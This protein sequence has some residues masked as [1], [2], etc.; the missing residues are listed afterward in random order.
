MHNEGLHSKRY[1]WTF[2]YKGR[3]LLP[4]ARRKLTEHQAAETASRQRMATLIQDPATFHNDASLQDLK[5]AIEKH[6]SLREQFQVYCH[7]FQRTPEKEFFLQLS[8]VVFFGLL[9]GEPEPG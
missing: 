6:S 4:Y 1:E 3:Q 8:D 7:E 5:R 2:A 9:E